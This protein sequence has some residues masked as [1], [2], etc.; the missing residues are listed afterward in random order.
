MVPMN[1]EALRGVTHPRFFDSER[2]FQAE[3]LANLRTALPNAG[4]PGEVAPE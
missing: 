1:M 4:L 2:G 3:F